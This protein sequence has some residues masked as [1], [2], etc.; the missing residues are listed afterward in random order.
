MVYGLA[1]LGCLFAGSIEQQTA[2]RF[3]QALGGGRRLVLARAVA[4]DLFGLA[5]AA[6]V[7]SWMHLLTMMATLVAPMIGTWLVLIDGWRTIFAMLFILCGLCLLMVTVRLNESLPTLFGLNILK[8]AVEI[9]RSPKWVA[10]TLSPGGD[11]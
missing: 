4:R 7:L 1:T 6:K 2:G 5:Q 9:A 10:R 11:Q 3:V 8:E